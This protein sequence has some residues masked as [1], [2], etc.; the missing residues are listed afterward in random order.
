MAGQYISLHTHTQF[1]LKDAIS[2]P[3]AMMRHLKNIGQDMVGITDH[4]VMYAISEYLKIGKEMGV[5][6]IPGCEFYV[7]NKGIED[8][9][10]RD[11]YHL[12]VLAVDRQGYQNLCKLHCASFT[13]GFYYDPRI[14]LD[15]LYK[16]RKGLVALSGCLG[17]ALPKILLAEGLAPAKKRLKSLIEIFGINDFY[18]ELQ[19]HGID[20]Q[21]ELEPV[22]CDLANEFELQCVATNDS[23][24]V[25]EQDW[26]PHDA[27]ICLGTGVTLNTPRDK[28]HVVYEPREFRLKSHD[29][30][31]ERFYESDLSVS[32]TIASS[33]EPLDL[34]SKTFHIP[35][36]QPS[37]EQKAK[38]DL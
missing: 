27:M 30:M 21:I 20:K 14:D 4:G 22:L 7:A 6:L 15:L 19:N 2:R 11:T 35:V 26:I 24:Y 16:H 13:Q 23:H 8:R 10:S 18:I 1:S 28:R 5:K 17:G 12:T 3:K 33:A 29:E 36:F 38:Y 34:S 31:A 37:K 25:E 32:H 9:S